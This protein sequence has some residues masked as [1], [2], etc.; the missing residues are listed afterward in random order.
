MYE[1]YIGPLDI[2]TEEEKRADVDHAYATPFE[3]RNRSEKYADYDTAYVGDVTY[4]DNS[5][6]AVR[7]QFEKIW[8]IQNV[9]SQSLG[10]LSV[11][12]HG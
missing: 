11:G 5:I 8:E 9:G 6:V 2:R 4:P 12:E 7:Q 10:W 3:L 1:D